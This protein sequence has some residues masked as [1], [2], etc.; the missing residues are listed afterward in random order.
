[1]AAAGKTRVA[2]SITAKVRTNRRAAEALRLEILRLAGRLG[3]PA[4]VRVRRVGDR[5]R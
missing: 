5:A 1:M 4:A 3:L 2:A